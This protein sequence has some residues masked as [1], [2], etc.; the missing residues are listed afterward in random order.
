MKS[1]NSF[2]GGLNLDV[3]IKHQPKDTYRFLLNGVIESSEG[4]LGAISNELGN[5]YCFEAPDGMTVIGHVSMDNDDIVIFSTDNNSS[6][7]GVFNTNTC[8][9]VTYIDASCLNFSTKNPVYALFRLRK[10]CER[11]IYFTDRLNKYRSINLDSLDQYKDSNGDWDCNKFNLSPDVILPK[12][13]SVSVN[14]TGGTLELGSYQFAIRLLDRDLNATNWLTITNPVIV[15]DESIS[16]PFGIINGGTNIPADGDIPIGAVPTTNKSITITISDIDVTYKYMQVA[17]LHATQGIGEV[18]EA[19]LVK[20]Q[21]VNGDSIEFVYRGAST[22]RGDTQIDVAEVVVDNEIID[23]VHDHAQKDNTL[24]LAGLT[25]KSYNY[26]DFQRAASKIKTIYTV[27]QSSIESSTTKGNAKN[28][29]TNFD[30]RSMPGDEI[31]ALGIEFIFKDS[32]KT[33]IFHIPG[34]PPNSSDQDELVVGTTVHPRNTR[35]LGLTTG[36][37]IERYKVFNSFPR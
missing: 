22:S 19:W 10:G 16:A 5:T 2:T 34:R 11:T 18:S 8:K 3:D 31:V 32:S 13:D 33:P 1:V 26:A 6:E 7:I 35:H 9:Y 30:F 15:Y 28:P 37:T 25:A 23:V 29:D 17:A 20:E 14:D 12:I 36:E 21:F 24:W 4:N 27:D